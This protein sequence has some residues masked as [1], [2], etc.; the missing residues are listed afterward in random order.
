MK[1]ITSLNLEPQ[2]ETEQEQESLD[3][4]DKGQVIE[5]PSL[6]TLSLAFMGFQ[7]SSSG[8]TMQEA[9]DGFSFI[10]NKLPN[11]KQDQEKNPLSH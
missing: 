1:P 11:I 2:E 7:I 4:S 6:P 3:E 10:I 5:P 8:Y 9:Q